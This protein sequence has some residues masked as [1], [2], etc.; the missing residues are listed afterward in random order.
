M[1]NLHVIPPGS[2]LKRYTADYVL[3]FEGAPPI[4]GTLPLWAYTTAQA[5]TLATRCTD[6]LAESKLPHGKLKAYRLD[7]KRAKS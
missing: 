2:R 1:S 3:E 6:G 7:V 5:V 4:A